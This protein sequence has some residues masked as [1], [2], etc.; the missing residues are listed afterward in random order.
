[1]ILGIQNTAMAVLACAFGALMLL[2]MGRSGKFFRAFGL[3]ALSGVAAL[4][5]VHFLS[6]FT[7]TDLAINPAT[8]GTS[9]VAGISGVVTLLVC[10]L[11]LR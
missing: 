1:M 9:A 11:I 3:S 8:L 10:K 7:G 6:Q 2:A 5:A 4:F